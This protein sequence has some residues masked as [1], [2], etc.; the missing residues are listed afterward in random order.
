MGIS[1]DINK[2]NHQPYPF[3]QPNSKIAVPT[4]EGIVFLKLQNILRLQADQNYTILYL[5]NGKKIVV[6]KS[7]ISF[8]KK[9]K[10]PPFFR[11]H[12]SHIVNFGLA[13]K[14]VRGK[15]GY[16]VLEDGTSV[17][18]SVRRKAAFLEALQNYFY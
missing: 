16:L 11:V 1:K 12:Q 14:Y 9:L 10:R 8:E 7:L 3:A 4:Q 5:T 17:D 18:V 6:C 13:V 2:T 15:G